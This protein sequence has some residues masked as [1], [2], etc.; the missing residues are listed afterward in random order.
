M[1]MGDNHSEVYL[2]NQKCL[3]ELYCDLEPI[4]YRE[5]QLALRF[6]THPAWVALLSKPV[7]LLR[8]PQYHTVFLSKH[9]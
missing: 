4:G 1:N 7:R 3:G 9:V 2:I 8:Q 5:A 6:L